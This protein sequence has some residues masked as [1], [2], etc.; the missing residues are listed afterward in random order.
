MTS[1]TTA[2]A[3]RHAHHAQALERAAALLLDVA[4]HLHHLAG[5]TTRKPETASRE[6]CRRLNALEAGGDPLQ[7]GQ[8]VRELLAEIDPSPS[9][10]NCRRAVSPVRQTGAANRQASQQQGITPPGV[11]P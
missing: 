4:E 8:R 7:I 2:E 11:K 9:R 5:T 6:L 3:K 10:R 1:T